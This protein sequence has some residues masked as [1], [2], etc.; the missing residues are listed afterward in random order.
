LANYIYNK[1]SGSI[2]EDEKATKMEENN[3]ISKIDVTSAAINCE[4]DMKYSE[5][6]DFIMNPTV[7]D[8]FSKE[9]D[10][11]VRKYIL[12]NDLIDRSMYDLKE[13]PKNV[14]VS[15]IDCND[16]M[17]EIEMFIWDSI[18]SGGHQ[19]GEKISE[20]IV[21]CLKKVYKDGKYL[22]KE[23]YFDYLKE[24]KLSDEQLKIERNNFIVTMKNYSLDVQVKCFS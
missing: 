20:E 3:N 7:A 19:E 2:S 12:D 4:F 23:L 5:I 24:F 10:Y 8:P 1:T 16:K 17:Q 11:C 13:N 21:D 15:S 18:S 9:Q 6:F 22:D 14:D